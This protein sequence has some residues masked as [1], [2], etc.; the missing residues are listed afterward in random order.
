M[1][2]RAAASGKGPAPGRRATG[3][4]LVIAVLLGL[5]ILI[6]LLVPLYDSEDPVLWG[7][8]F[9]YWFQ[10]LLIPIV[11]VLTYTAFK[12]SEKALVKDREAHGL[13]GHPH[14]EGER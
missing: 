12:I 8:P 10:F 1:S 2:D 7:F 3:P 4:W 9:F 14:R 11:S 13:P 6:P 5:G